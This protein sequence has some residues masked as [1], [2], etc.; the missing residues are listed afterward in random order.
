M[1]IL[2]N[3][4]VFSPDPIGIHDI[5]I[6]GGKIIGIAPSIL[7]PSGIEVE[8][9][10]M[11]NTTVAPGFID[12]HVHIAGAGG[13]GGPS[14]RTPEMQLSQFITA[15]VTTVVGCLGTDG[16][17]RSVESVL[18][19]A[20]SLK[21]E[22]I[23]AYIYS[24]AYQVP[25]PSILGEIGK[26]I[27]MIEEV[28]GVGE[29]ALSDHRSSWPSTDEL[30]R[31]TEHARVGGMLGG[32]AGI[33]NI[34][35]GDQ[36]DPFQ[37]L[38]KVI[39]QSNNMLK[40]TQFIPTHCNRNDYTLDS[41]VEYG[42]RGGIVDITTSSYPY[43]KEYEVKPSKCINIL[44]NAGVPMENIMFTSDAGGSLPGFDDQGNL[45]MLQM[46]TP[47]SNW[48]EI[49]DA[50]KNEGVDL[51][52]AL[53]TITSNPA[54]LLKLKNKGWIKIGMDADLIAI[55]NDEITHVIA[56]G[57]WMMKEKKV[58]RKGAYEK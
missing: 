14:T 57:Q 43:F 32:K 24:G 17:T 35:L 8:V 48:F 19:K 46:G 45:T 44:R 39:E 47:H 12:A 22:G 30:L 49:S 58:L 34:H 21:A 31:I 36:E 54:R 50:V 53:K 25:T 3:C 40:L 27:A 52:D 13:E 26:D 1:I 4:N 38:Y 33:I 11:Q 10:D 55:N 28:I 23:S 15:G 18:M 56:M 7:P 9:Y 16:F 37:P 6:A 29:I 5:L 2:K 41:A 51:G 42:K 20:K